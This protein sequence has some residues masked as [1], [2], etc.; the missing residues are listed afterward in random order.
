M[1]CP[2]SGLVLDFQKEAFDGP[3]SDMVVIFRDVF[4]CFFFVCFVFFCCFVFLLFVVFDG[5][6]WFVI[7][8]VLGFSSKGNIFCFQACLAKALK[9][10]AL[11]CKRS[12]ERASFA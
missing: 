5:F 8:F 6:C 1:W 11:D 7:V 9:M 2:F 12:Y 4:F 3:C 10:K